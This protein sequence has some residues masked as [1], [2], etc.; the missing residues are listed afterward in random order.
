MLVSC[1]LQFS[2]FVIELFHKLLTSFVVASIAF[3]YPLNAVSLMLAFAS[4]VLCYIDTEGTNMSSRITKVSQGICGTERP[5]SGGRNAW[6]NATRECK[7]RFPLGFNAPP[8]H[9]L[10]GRRLLR[11]SLLFY[12]PLAVQ[13]SFSL[14]VRVWASSRY[15]SLRHL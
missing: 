5:D 10:I 11:K 14:Y 12:L 4:C 6:Y 3:W 7:V 8:S 2:S 9:H 15:R 13:N 1:T